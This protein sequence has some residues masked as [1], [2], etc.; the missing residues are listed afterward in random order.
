MNAIDKIALRVEL[1]EISQEEGS[2]LAIELAKRHNELIRRWMMDIQV[3]RLRKSIK[4]EDI[5]KVL[6]ALPVLIKHMN[7]FPKVF[8]SLGTT[9]AKASESFN[10]T[11]QLL[12][13]LAT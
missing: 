7:E 13:M 3:E 1:G 12:N 4:P 8:T 11:A 10:T 6:K 9:V 5:P 2:K